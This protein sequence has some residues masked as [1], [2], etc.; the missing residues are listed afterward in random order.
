[1]GTWATI[2]VIG[3]DAA[4]DEISAR[5]AAVDRAFRWFREV[6][7]TCSRFD[8]SSELSR[9]SQTV[10]ADV[11]TSD[12]LFRAIEF[13]CA[14]A[15]ESDGAFDPTV[16]RSMVAL[17]FNRHYLTGE[18]VGSPPGA[19]E[20]S[21]RDVHLDSERRTIRLA[22]PLQLD[23]G[24]VAKGL[25]IDL[26]ARELT[27]LGRFVVDAGGDLYLAGTNAAGEAWGI[28]VR[29]PRAADALLGTIRVSG[30]AVCTSGD[31]ERRGA[32]SAG[33]HLINPKTG[34]PVGTVASVTVVAPTAMVADAIGTAAFVLGAEAGLELCARAGVEG[35]VV[36]TDLAVTMTPGMKDA[37]HPHA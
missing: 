28:G 32:E 7:A 18:R 1:M 15:A 20:A 17:G 10:G 33:H 29:H 3:H 11:P 19:G 26:A 35:L 22:R 14:V 21:W 2:D 37:F 13:A 6:E 16:G 5:E 9:L 24:A 36:S 8:P 25:A 34:Q 31:Y 27:P 12:L 23:L 4:P 30:L